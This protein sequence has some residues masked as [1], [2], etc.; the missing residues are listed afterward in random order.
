MSSQQIIL[1]VGE[2]PRFQGRP[3]TI[4]GKWAVELTRAINNQ[5]PT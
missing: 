3:G 1:R 4:A 2:L 5:P